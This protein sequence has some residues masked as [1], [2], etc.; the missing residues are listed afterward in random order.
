MTDVSLADPTELT[1]EAPADT[2]SDL[3]ALEASGETETA[4]FCEPV[5][6]RI[7]TCD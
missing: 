1:L 4:V 6:D 3:A 2:Q 7:R 5:L